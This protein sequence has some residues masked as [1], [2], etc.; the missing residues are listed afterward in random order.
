M[1]NVDEIRLM[2]TALAPGQTLREICP[3]CG[4]GSTKERSLAVSLTEDGY[5]A[6]FCHRASCE[7][8]GKELAWGVV[9]RATPKPP[10]PYTG[11]LG[12][13]EDEHYDWLFDR[14]GI[15][16]QTADDLHYRCAIEDNRI[17]IPVFGPD[18][19]RRGYDNRAI[20]TAQQPKSLIYK[21]ISDEP[22]VGWYLHAGQDIWPIVVE[23]CFSAAK[24]FQAGV[25]AVFLTGTHLSLEKV[26][27]LRTK[28]DGIVLALDGDA[29]PKAVKYAAQFGHL[30]KFHVWQLERDLKY[31][32]TDDILR[33]YYGGA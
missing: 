12:L 4:G 10:K 5:L 24:V 22:F 14:F 26:R 31:E 18:R 13:L 19:Q 17:A 8:R 15:L 29:F 1:T 6:W 2:G 33:R 7:A 16:K 32:E 21:E 11:S 27:E 23:D 25:N 30:L 20:T 3:I 28:Y 9:R